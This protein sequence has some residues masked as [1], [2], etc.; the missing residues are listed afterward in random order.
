MLFS[1]PVLQINPSVSLAELRRRFEQGQGKD[2][3]E[4]GLQIGDSLSENPD[5]QLIFSKRLLEEAKTSVPGSLMLARVY[6]LVSDGY[7]FSDSLRLSSD[8][9]FSA[10]RIAE[11]M[12]P[13]DTFFLG[14]AYCDMG[15]NLQ[16]LGRREEARMYLNKAIVF[17]NSA[18][19]WE[20]L[21]DAKSN[22][23]A[24]SYTEGN[25]EEAITLFK[26]T[27]TIDLKTGNRNRQSSSL[28]NLGRIYIDWG[29][30]D[31]GL[32]YYL[33]SLAL[34]DTLH[35]RKTLSV[36][37][38]NIGMAYQMMNRHREAIQW[39][40]KARVINES[41]GMS[42]QLGTRYFNLAN[43]WMALKKYDIAM[44]CFQKAHYWCVETEQFHLLAK[45]YAGT[46]QLLLL[47]GDQTRALNNFLKSLEYAEKG[48]S[49]T[50]KSDSYHNLYRYYKTTGQP[51][52]ALRY[53]E[54]WST[55]KDSS[56]NLEVSRQV[57]DLEM[58]YRTAQ[59]E[60]EISRLEAEN[61]LRIREISFRKKERNWA[62]A[63]LAFLLLFLGGL[64]FLF[65]TVKRQKAVLSIQNQELERLNNLQNR[66]FGII[67]HDLKNATSAYQ[68]SAKIISHYLARGE[69]QKLSP[70]A[71][72]ISKNAKVLSEMLENLLQWSVW[73]MKGID[74]EKEVIPVTREAVRVA[75]LLKEYASGKN[76]VIEVRTNDETVWCDLES[77]SL[78]LRNLVSNGLKFTSSGTVFIRSFPDGGYTAIE[79]ADTGCG[80]DDSILRD[81]FSSGFKEARRGSSGEKGAGLGLMLVAEHLEK[82]NGTIRVKSRPDEGTTFTITLPSHKS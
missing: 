22:L 70:L 51:A 61:E 50:E 77:F 42:M 80:M 15:L 10:I 19:D 60:A 81:L 73:Q 27:Y 45:V 30:Y 20:S 21:A 54:Y 33:K 46:G 35:D 38:N 8:Y 67:S 74:P 25:F 13:Q 72:E 26:E 24:L 39:I 49:L 75:E 65:T 56:F 7:F 31:T 34:V 41:E 78:I 76:N 2:R 17:L 36:R 55:V 5:E 52:L 79:V 59:K 57:E 14:S 63:G 62:I 4:T 28:N 44:T 66:L 68:S 71:P 11:S 23:A 32:E 48:G 37:Y 29:K 16:D 47:L 18:G 40:E 43:S 64:S 9:L 58:Q 1:L 69:P 82:N 3:I 6:R 12:A 53:H